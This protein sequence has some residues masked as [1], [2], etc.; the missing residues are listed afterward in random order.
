MTMQDKIYV[1]A[2]EFIK[3]MKY[4][5]DYI[6][7][8]AKI[9]TDPEILDELSKDEDYR[10]RCWVA[11]N[12]NITP[13]TLN[14]LSKD[15]YWWVRYWVALNH[16]TSPETLDSLSKDKNPDVRCG[17]AR[18]SNTS[19]ETLDYLSK[20][21][22][23]DVRYWV[24]WNRNTSPETLVYLSKD[25]DLATRDK[26]KSNPN[27]PNIFKRIKMIFNRT[28]NTTENNDNWIQDFENSIINSL[29]EEAKLVYEIHK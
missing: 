7:E 15:D 26:A 13:E 11:Q 1:K 19:P 28:K 24:A 8:L 2:M 29:S 23:Y 20:H 21:E 4:E 10:V 27:Y 16:N 6:K 12:P 3:D 25:K 17:V 5:E 9:T 18:N 14:Y 22:D